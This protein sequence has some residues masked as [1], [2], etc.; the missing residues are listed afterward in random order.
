MPWNQLWQP[1]SRQCRAGKQYIQ[2]VISG[3][4]LN[5]NVLLEALH[6]PLVI[7]SRHN[8]H[9][10]RYSAPSTFL[11]SAPQYLILCAY[12]SSMPYSILLRNECISGFTTSTAA[13]QPDTAQTSTRPTW[14]LSLDSSVTV[15]IMLK[16]LF[17]VTGSPLLDEIIAANPK[18]P[19]GKFYRAEVASIL[20]DALQSG[21][22][23]ARIEVDE[24]ADEP[25]K[26]H[27]ER[28]RSRLEAGE[29][30]CSSSSY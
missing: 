29:L 13:L 17:Q 14:A 27:F 18:G 24:T 6:R 12:P 15:S 11:G 30:V 22:S 28:F 19:P 16:D 8:H 3:L 1:R 21:G 7:C 23:S 4:P 10:R 25:Q 26:E 5:Y 20:V 2:R 9:L